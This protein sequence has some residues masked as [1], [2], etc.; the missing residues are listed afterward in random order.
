LKIIGIFQ[1]N[2]DIFYREKHYFILINGKRFSANF[3]DFKQEIIEFEGYVFEEGGLNE[4]NVVE[5][6]LCDEKE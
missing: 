6:L 1:I 4:K 2:H 5:V 3:D